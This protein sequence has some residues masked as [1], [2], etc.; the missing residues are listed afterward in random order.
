MG[1][2]CCSESVVHVHVDTIDEFGDECRVVTLLAR[3]KSQV[4]TKFNSWSQLQQSF[5]NRRQRIFCGWFAFGSPEMAHTHHLGATFR[6]PCDR[7][8]GGTYT[9][10]VGNH[11]GIVGAAHRHVEIRAHE[12]RSS[13]H[14]AE[15]FQERK[16]HGVGWS[17][18]TW[19]HSCRCVG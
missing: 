13:T 2:V 10:I 7:G 11:A 4:L 16:F 9:K 19:R 17:V 14:I 8:K 15:V 18:V 1:S 12:H 5:A 3:G 6:Q